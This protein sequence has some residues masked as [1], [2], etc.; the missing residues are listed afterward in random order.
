[1]IPTKLFN[2]SR[3]GLYRRLN[4]KPQLWSWSLYFI[5]MNDQELRLKCLEFVTKYSS[6]DFPVYQM[7]EAEML[8]NYLKTGELP[9]E[10][11]TSSSI[12]ASDLLKS[13]LKQ[14]FKEIEQGNQSAD[15]SN[16]N[17]SKLDV[18]QSFINRFLSKLRREKP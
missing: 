16:D 6:F 15:G 5:A 1:M 3:K 13:S 10:G 14:L 12:S 9:V 11:Y 2:C 8:F 17:S 7:I 18:P 4:F